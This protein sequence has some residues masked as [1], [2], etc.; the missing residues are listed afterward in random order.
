MASPSILVPALDL[1]FRLE[2]YGGK[3]KRARSSEEQ[4]IGILKAAE[5]AGN[6]WGVCQ[7]HNITQQTFCRWRRKYAARESPGGPKRDVPRELDFAG[8]RTDGLRVLYN[9]EPKS[10]TLN[11]MA[12]V[13]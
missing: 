13:G 5:A 9:C 12:E 2:I 4:I 6:I 8:C 3:M 1:D 7:E 10:A 11:H